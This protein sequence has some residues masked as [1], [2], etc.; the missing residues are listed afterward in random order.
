VCLPTGRQKFESLP[1]GRQV[2]S[3]T[4]KSRFAPTEQA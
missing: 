1:T 4:P 3:G 2:A